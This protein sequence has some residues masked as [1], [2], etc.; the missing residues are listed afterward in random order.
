MD[1][2]RRRRLRMH[3]LLG[4]MLLGLRLLVGLLVGLSM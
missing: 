2:K 3:V 1:L 4:L